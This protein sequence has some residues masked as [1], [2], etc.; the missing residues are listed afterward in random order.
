MG[1][2]FSG[3]NRQR[4]RFYHHSCLGA[5]SL[6]PGSA[7]FEPRR[8]QGM[9]HSDRRAGDGRVLRV[10]GLIGELRQVGP[11]RDANKKMNNLR[12]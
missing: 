4:W 12:V 5:F 11:R 2:I 8:S 1:N 9:G 10:R 6:R 7:S 3:C